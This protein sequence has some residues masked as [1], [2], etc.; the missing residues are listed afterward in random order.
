MSFKERVAV[1]NRAVFLNLEY[2]ADSHTVEYDG[3][4]YTD[5]PLVLRGLKE[6]ERRQLA[7]D[8]AQGLYLAS[9]VMHGDVRDLGGNVPERGMR[10]KVS[11]GGNGFMREFYVATS[12]CQMG[13]LRV[14][15]EAIDE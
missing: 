12:D 3:I 8:H 6:S 11:D 2:F 14:E 10:I 13:M 4:T 1:D 9:T 7:A 15:L 5:I